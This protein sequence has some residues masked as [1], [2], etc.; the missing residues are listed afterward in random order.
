MQKRRK[1][2]IDRMPITFNLDAKICEHIRS[3]AIAYGSMT[4]YV[5]HIINDYLTANSDNNG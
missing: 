2:G 5:E 3:H 4:A 1:D